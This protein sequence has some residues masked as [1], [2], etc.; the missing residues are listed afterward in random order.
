MTKPIDALKTITR[1]VEAKKPKTLA[2]AE[3]M[4][5]LISVLADETILGEDAAESSLAEGLIFKPFSHRS[6][7]GSAGP[8]NGTFST[9]TEIGSLFHGSPSIIDL[10]IERLDLVQNLLERAAATADI[11]SAVGLA[12][13]KSHR[14]ADGSSTPRVRQ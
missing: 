13:E 3:H 1:Y 9:S 14:G 4:L 10:D 5:H 6:S 7:T 2:E 12:I 11:V 8:V